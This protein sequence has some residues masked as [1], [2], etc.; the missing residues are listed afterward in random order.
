MRSPRARPTTRKAGPG[1]ALLPVT[2]GVI[3]IIIIPE[4]GLSGFLG[5]VSFLIHLGTVATPILT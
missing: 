1:L 2:E 3:I 5:S 4:S